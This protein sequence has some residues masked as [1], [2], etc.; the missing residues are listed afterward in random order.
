M[1]PYKQPWGRDVAWT[2]TLAGEDAH[3]T[4]YRR[5]RI[6]EQFKK[7]LGIIEHS[8]VH[9]DFVLRVQK[10]SA[11]VATRRVWKSSKL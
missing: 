1:H 5:F 4:K 2:Q 9:P 10:N 6:G 8:S 11:S 3:A 7:E